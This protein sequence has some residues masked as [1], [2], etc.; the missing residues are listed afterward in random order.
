MLHTPGQKEAKGPFDSERITLLAPM[1]ACQRKSEKGA[2][3]KVLSYFYL[4]L[5]IQR[6]TEMKP[7]V[8]KNT[9]LAT[10]GR[11]GFNDSHLRQLS[12]W[13]KQQQVK[14]EIICECEI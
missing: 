6:H 14:L 8:K 12:T 11:S 2:N 10:D 13:V 3:D 7:A 9:Q 5:K 4:S 1:W